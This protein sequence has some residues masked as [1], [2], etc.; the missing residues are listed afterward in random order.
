MALD[1]LAPT[2][3][4]ELLRLQPYETTAVLFATI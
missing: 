1:T 4:T 2:L 3:A